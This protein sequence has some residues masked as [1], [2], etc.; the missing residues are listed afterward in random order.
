MV[1]GLHVYVSRSRPI[2]NVYLKRVEGDFIVEEILDENYLSLINEDATTKTY[3]LMKIKKPYGVDTSLLIEKLS[4]LGVSRKKI[5]FLGLKDKFSTAVQHLF[6]HKS[7]VGKLEQALSRMAID[8]SVVGYTSPGHITRSILYGNKFDIRLWN[9]KDN[10]F[11]ENFF[12][13]YPP[14][15][16]PNFFGYQRFGVHRLNH[17]LG[18]LILTRGRCEYPDTAKPIAQDFVDAVKKVFPGTNIYSEESAFKHIS[19]FPKHHI[20]FLVNAYQSYLFNIVLSKRIMDGLPIDRCVPGD[21]YMSNHGIEICR[22]DESPHPPL[23][24]I[25]GYMHRLKNERV[26]D[27][28]YMEL[29]KEEGIVLRDFYLRE[30]GDLRIYGGFRRASLNV[31][32]LSYYK[33][34]GDIRLVFGL[35]R[36]MYATILIRELVKPSEPSTQGF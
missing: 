16:L 35:E 27:R 2:P 4:S 21:Y 14:S 36:G 11:I 24:P 9:L 30:Y 34:D 23:I 20:R 1:I 25:L 12:Q 8:F 31:F 15:R 5:F 32:Q 13:E 3:V 26:M 28:Y 18:K 10:H 17:I 22:N 19:R 33:E 6:V 29:M 7:I